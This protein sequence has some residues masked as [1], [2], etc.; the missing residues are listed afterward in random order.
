LFV[1][2]SDFNL[3]ALSRF[4]NLISLEINDANNITNCGI[5]SIFTLSKLSQLY[6]EGGRR[7]TDSG[8][9][10]ISQ[11]KKLHLLSLQNL[12]CISTLVFAHI[13]KLKVLSSLTMLWCEEI[14]TLG[15][16]YLAKLS[17]C[18]TSLTLDISTQ[19]TNRGVQH[20]I[21]LTKL[22]SLWL[23][24]SR[25]GDSAKLKNM[26]IKLYFALTETGLRSLSK[27]QLSTG[28]QNYIISRI[29]RT[30]LFF[31]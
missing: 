22:K 2:G 23:L 14:T 13:A 29:P 8:F 25:T 21:Q 15:L 4:K 27:L 31:N 18:L 17:H 7:I 9:R 12:P 30:S 16:K 6:I 11:L 26:S 19:T 20:F 28:Q 1:G 24:V 3:K 10:E 5:A